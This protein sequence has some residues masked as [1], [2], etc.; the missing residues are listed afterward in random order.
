MI[1]R[2]LV[3]AISSI[4]MLSAAQADDSLSSKPASEFTTQQN[5]AVL[6]QLPFDDKQ[7]F[8]FAAKGLIAKPELKQ[9]KNAKGEVVWDLA[10][11]DF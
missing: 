1:K 10:K 8:E 4:L 9:I 6:S 5:Y 11:F 7:D 3:A 2:I